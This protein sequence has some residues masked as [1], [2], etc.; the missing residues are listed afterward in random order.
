M[1]KTR[2][3]EH[4]TEK[5]TASLDLLERYGE[6]LPGSAIRALLHF[7]SDRSFRRAA[8]KQAL[9]IPVFRVPG[10]RG[11]FARTRDVVAWLDRVAAVGSSLASTVKPEED[12]K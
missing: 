10:R 4:G 3:M 1:C 5:A 6:L 12:D 2:E 8:A 11:W 9:P 7:S